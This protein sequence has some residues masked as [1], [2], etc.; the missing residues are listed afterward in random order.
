MICRRRHSYDIARSGY[1]N[2]LQPQDRRSLKAGDSRAA[3]DARTRLLEKGIGRAILDAFVSRA[4]SLAVADNSVVVD[5]GSGA[6]D[7]LGSLSERRAIVGIGIDL[8]PAA[9]TVAAR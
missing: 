9:A 4:A 7:V 1:I 3:V 2:L 6:G 5:L 8:S